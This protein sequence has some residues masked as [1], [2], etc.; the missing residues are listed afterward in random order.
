MV[1]NINPKSSNN[2]QKIGISNITTSPNYPQENGLVE[3][4]IQTF[5]KKNTK[6]YEDK[7]DPYLALLS[8]RMTPLKDGS[9]SS[10]QQMMKRIIL[11]NLHNI[12]HNIYLK[13]K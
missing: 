1:R 7:Q 6:A 4:N 2:L 8:L 10:A 13:K 11:T 3:S 12:K 5:K 9:P